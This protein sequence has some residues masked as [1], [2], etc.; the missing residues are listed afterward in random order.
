[1]IERKIFAD[2]TT[3]FTDNDTREDYRR[4]YGGVAW[5]GK[6]PGFIVLVGESM[7]PD[8]A[9]REHF[10]RMLI[11]AEEQDVPALL[12]RCIELKTATG[13]GLLKSVRHN[14]YITDGWFADTS[15]LPGMEIVRSLNDE[16]IERKKES[17]HLSDAP[18]GDGK[19]GFIFCY[20]VLRGLLSRNK[21]VLHLG[22]QS[23]L[24]SL[25]LEVSPEKLIKASPQDYPS[26]A[27]L[28]Y[29]VAA[30]VNWKPQEEFKR[31]ESVVT[32]Y[33]HST[34]YDGPI[35]IY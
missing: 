17:L 25:L 3:Y 8:G 5:P 28:G 22:E 33:D 34:I 27:A 21:K 26:I 9:V 32:P 23:K 31:P 29:A 16:A 13:I 10:Y 2:G 20:N 4:V 18:G 1:M 11:E 19:D 15:Y 12:R 14:T 30:L 7:T 6:R 24:P 35:D